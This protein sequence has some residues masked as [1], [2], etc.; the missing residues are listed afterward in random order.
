MVKNLIKEAFAT[1]ATIE[2]AVANAKAA[3][4]APEDVD[5][6]SE[7]VERPQKKI[8]G[9]FGGTPAKARAY[10]EYEEKTSMNKAVD[11]L[12]GILKGMGM[13]AKADARE[14][15]EDIIIDL[16]CGDDYGIVIGRRGETLDAIQYL[17]RLVVNKCSDD[18]KRVSINIGDYREK[19]E[20]TLISLAHKNAAKVAKYGRNVTLEPM[21]PFER[22]IIHTAVQDV[23]GVTSHS[24]GTDADRRVVITLKDGVKPTNPSKGGYGRGKGGYGKGRGGYNKGGRSKGPRNDSSVAPAE[25]RAPRTDAGAASV[26]RY[27]KLN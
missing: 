20:K 6:K 4:N 8:L 11:Y 17:T 9:L 3:L 26:S 24:V 19:R 22:R 25:A 18:Y 16:D 23:E 7:I 12:L 27:G 2:E 13:D 10:Y 21:N 14:E 5:V 1:G 15:G